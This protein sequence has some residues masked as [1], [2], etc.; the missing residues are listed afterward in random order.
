MTQVRNRPGPSHYAAGELV[1]VR[2]PTPSG[3][4]ETYAAR[5]V[6]P[7]RTH[8]HIRVVGTGSELTLTKWDTKLFVT[9]P[10]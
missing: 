5:V 8:L 9:R 4:M 1:N 7:S 6:R 10:G 2:R 3:S